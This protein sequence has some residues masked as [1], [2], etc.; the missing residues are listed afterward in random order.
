MMTS[1]SL[2][3]RV[4]A[5]KEQVSCDLAGETVLLSLLNGQYFGLNS[6]GAVIWDLLQG[7]HTVVELRDSLLRQYP[8]VTPDRCTQDLLELLS[9]LE[10]AVLVQITR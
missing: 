7:T 4:T 3:S 6:V 5:A 9:E 10:D 8:D 2:Q 1:L